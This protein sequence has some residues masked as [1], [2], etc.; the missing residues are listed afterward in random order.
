MRRGQLSLFLIIAAVIIIIGGL[1]TYLL[2]RV[3]SEP[4][5]TIGVRTDLQPVEAFVT[6]CLEQS[7][8]ASLVAIGET[9]G[10]VDPV[11]DG[12]VAN[13]L[14]PTESKAFEPFQNRPAMPYWSYLASAND[15][16]TCVEASE[17]PA[18]LGAAPAIQ[19]QLENDISQ[20][21]LTCIDEFSTFAEQYTIVADKDPVVKVT[22]GV[23]DTIVSMSYPIKIES[24]GGT[25]LERSEFIA[26]VDVPLK[27]L[28]DTASSIVAQAQASGF[29]EGLTLEAITLESTDDKLPPIASGY[30]L[31][32]SPGP[33]W[34]LFQVRQTVATALQRDIGIVQLFASRSMSFV[35]S[36]DSTTDRIYANYY[37]NIPEDV[38]SLDASFIYLSR[39]EPYVRVSPGGQIIK[40]DRLSSHLF[41]LPQFKM[42]DFQYDV[43]YPVLVQ[44]SADTSQGP[45]VFQFPIEV[46]MRNNKVLSF[47]PYGDD[48]TAQESVC[49]DAEAIGSVVTVTTKDSSA[50]APMT[51]LVTYECLSD[52][53]SYGESENGRLTAQLPPCVG[54]AL[55]AEREGFRTAR[56]SI[57]SISSESR[58]V[59]MKL[60]PLKETTV[61]VRPMIIARESRGGTVDKPELGAWV[62]QGELGSF[63]KPYKAIITFVPVDDPEYA[64]VAVVPAPEDSTPTNPVQL[65][66]GDYDVTA[67][68]LQSLT[69]VHVL[70]GR[71][72]CGGGVLGIGDTC[73][74]I[75]DIKLGEGGTVT[76]EDGTE[77][78]A[79]AGEIYIGG[80]VRDETTSR[81]T[82]TAEML[83]DG[84]L[85][86]PVIIIS[87]AE[88]QVIEDMEALDQLDEFSADLWLE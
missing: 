84:I 2:M 70:R 15:C 56:V 26:K 28:Y 7:T 10:Y 25:A 22:F 48:N 85:T 24:S 43:S 51:A 8:R 32:F 6:S 65:A 20:R 4:D 27:Q 67:V 21:T 30:D 12:Y 86:V 16:T 46:N 17:K 3:N 38:S 31:G 77:A 1:A 29:F 45:Y 39:W 19:G 80:M 49:G 57:D 44:L 23:R 37:F 42:L 83:G 50:D 55:V 87:L 82:I 78:Q 72:I 71:E 11:A 66:P 68:V 74:T 61:A 9:G 36:G 60:T 35:K 33:I 62:Q 13:P 40:P 41:F 54:G 5:T 69:E 14:R 34:A 58:Q 64:Q 81:M 59:D 88:L 47:A 18:L 53:C 63:D 79:P 75:P 73:E 52:A 76:L